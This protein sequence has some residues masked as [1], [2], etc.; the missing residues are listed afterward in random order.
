MRVARQAA[1]GNSQELSTVA[2]SA[3]GAEFSNIC[4]RRRRTMAKQW[5]ITGRLGELQVQWLRAHYTQQQLDEALARLPKKGYPLNV[6]RRLEAE[7]GPRMPSPAELLAAD[8]ESQ[9][10]AA[11]ELIHQAVRNMGFESFE[12][13]KEALAKLPPASEADLLLCEDWSDDELP[14]GTGAGELSG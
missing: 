7:G 2:R 5:E 12:A 13:Y 11:Q 10:K 9:Q 3:E 8:P 14:L 1:V 6:S 4:R